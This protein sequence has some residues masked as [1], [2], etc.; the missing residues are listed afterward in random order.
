MKCEY[1][2]WQWNGQYIKGHK[3]GT[4]KTLKTALDKAKE[5][6]GYLEIEKDKSGDL[7]IISDNL[8]LPIGMIEKHKTDS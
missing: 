7:Y 8:Q 2:L 3:V 4:W 6:P 5:F 1:T